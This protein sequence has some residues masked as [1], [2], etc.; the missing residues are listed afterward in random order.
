MTRPWIKQS[1]AKLNDARL[2]FVSDQAQRDYF[3]LY[4]LA[5]QLDHEGLFFEGER[6]LSDK[7]IAFR[8]HINEPRLKKSYKEL[9]TEGLL[10]INGKGP[11]ITDWS[12]EQI[13]W[14]DKQER[15]RERQ[16]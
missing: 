10:H 14:R 9:K 12:I 5:G 11:L 15:E 16:Q 3:M 1:T 7:E 2:S 4:L 13:N 8:I 6:R